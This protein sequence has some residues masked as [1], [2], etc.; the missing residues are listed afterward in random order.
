MG[1]RQ[2]W[3]EMVTLP[4]EQRYRDLRTGLS[5]A[6]IAAIRADGGELPEAAGLDPVPY[7]RPMTAGEA[8]AIHGIGSM[9][10]RVTDWMRG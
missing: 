3:R 8:K 6:E 1:L 9:I 7:E 2:Q 10:G 5:D 4:L